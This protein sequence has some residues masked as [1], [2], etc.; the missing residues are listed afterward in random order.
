MAYYK[1]SCDTDSL[2]EP[3]NVSVYS[4]ELNSMHAESI[5][6]ILFSTTQTYGLIKC[7]CSFVGI[8]TRLSFLLHSIHIGLSRA[9]VTNTGENSVHDRQAWASDHSDHN[10]DNDGVLLSSSPAIAS[11]LAGEALAMADCS[12]DC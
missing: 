5:C 12:D 8:T 11:R 6:N 9:C 2:Q 4:M 3:I 7:H 1:F 10:D